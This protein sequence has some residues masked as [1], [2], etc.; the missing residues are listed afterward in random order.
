MTNLVDRPISPKGRR[1]RERLV[2]AGIA[3]LAKGGWPAVTTRGVA[4]RARVNPGLIHYHFGGLGGLHATVARRAGDMVLNPLVTELLGA[5]DTRAGLALLSALLP[6]TAGEERTVRLA[7]ALIEGAMRD[8]ALGEVLRHQLR[9]T[10]TQ[11]ADRLNELHPDRPPGW[12]AGVATLIAALV[13]GLML[14]YLLDS[15]LPVGEALA[16]LADLTEPDQAG[17]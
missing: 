1:Q 9:D 11:A 5:S 13:D 7:V 2:D 15:D 16:A 10:R 3:L 14:H 8:P 4:E 6:R 12:S 17:T